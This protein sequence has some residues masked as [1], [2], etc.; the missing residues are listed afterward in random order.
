MQPEVYD[1]IYSWR[2]L[3]DDWKKTHGGETKVLLTEAYANMTFTMKY[4]QSDDGLRKGSHIPF[5]FLMISDLN[6]DSSA[7]DFVHI[8]SEW[9]SFM[10]AGETANWVVSINYHTI[11]FA[12]AESHFHFLLIFLSAGQS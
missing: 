7:N 8:V 1:I 4:Y 12:T 5:N 6:K 11:N 3:L 2:D 9:M 10:P